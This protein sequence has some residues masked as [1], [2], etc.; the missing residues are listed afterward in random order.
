[1][2][3]GGCLQ[4]YVGQWMV[5]FWDC[6]FV[7]RKQGLFLSVFVDDIKFAGKKA[8]LD[9]MWKNMMTHV[10]LG[11]LRRFLITCTCDALNTNVNQTQV[12]LTNT[13][14]IRFANL[15]RSN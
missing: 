12:W 7:H 4:K 9:P 15:C 10:D 5:P 6:P 1:M 3:S 8:N 14:H 13:E 11:E 2:W